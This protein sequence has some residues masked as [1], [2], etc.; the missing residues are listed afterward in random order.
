MDVVDIIGLPVQAVLEAFHATGLSWPACVIALCLLVRALL[1]PAGYLRRKGTHT[2]AVISLRRS[3]ELHKLHHD[4]PAQY[5]QVFS[6]LYAGNKVSPASAFG[7]YVLQL[8]AFILV[9]AGLA[10]FKDEFAGVQWLSASFG[11]TA[12][13]S[14]VG[15]GLV[16]LEVLLVLGLVWQSRGWYAQASWYMRIGGILMA[17]LVPGLIGLI[18]WVP[19]LIYVVA[20]IASAYAERPVMRY[21]SRWRHGS[22]GWPIYDENGDVLTYA[23]EEDEGPEPAL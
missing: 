16:I 3:I 13:Q 14:N 5:R 9:S 1:I 8:I 17:V 7:W 6:Q 22:R 4:D 12:A 21:Y 11:M 18:L 20:T 10:S 19:V 23:F 15:I 2:L